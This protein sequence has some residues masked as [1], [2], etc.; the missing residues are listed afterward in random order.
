M[1]TT[2]TVRAQTRRTSK[3]DLIEYRFS[4]PTA[5]IIWGTLLSLES[6]RVSLCCGTH[7]R[8]IR[9]TNDRGFSAI[10]DQQA[11]RCT[12]AP[13]YW[14][15]FS[16]P[17]SSRQSWPSARWP[18]GSLIV[19]DTAPRACVI[20]PAAVHASFERRSRKRSNSDRLLR[21]FSGSARRPPSWTR[22]YIDRSAVEGLRGFH[23]RL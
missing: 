2:I 19:W 22:G 9:L 18:R 15:R 10:A 13:T 7:F 3:P 5:T 16:R 23:Q 6:V 14:R 20:L 4:E 8:G 21:D 1:R 11:K 12:A 17:F